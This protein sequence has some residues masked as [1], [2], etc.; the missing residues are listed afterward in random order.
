MPATTYAPTHLARAVPSALRGLTSV[1][2]MGTGG[3][4]TAPQ[5]YLHLIPEAHPPI[6]QS[7]NSYETRGYEPHPEL[8]IIP[9]TS[10]TDRFPHDHANRTDAN[11]QGNVDNEQRG[12]ALLIIRLEIPTQGNHT[13]CQHNQDLHEGRQE[14]ENRP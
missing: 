12:E 11:E 10:G 14:R 5:R 2:G 3:P 6:Q 8:G 7:E 4:R 1:F 13:S 9:G